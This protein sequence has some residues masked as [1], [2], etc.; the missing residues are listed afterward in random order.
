LQTGGSLDTDTT[1]RF[2][3]VARE[4]AARGVGLVAFDEQLAA[5]CALLSGH[6]AEMDT[7]EGKTLV[8]ALA[9]AGHALAG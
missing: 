7:G 8:G 3:A 2:L 4:A 1:A 5:C 9:A 6:A